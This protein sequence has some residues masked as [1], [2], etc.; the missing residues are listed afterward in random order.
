M[1][2]VA[3]WEPDFEK[4]NRSFG[5]RPNKSCHDAI[6][7]LQSNHTIGLTMALEGDISAAYDNVR[8][9]DIIRCLEMKIRDRKFMRFM[10]TRLNYD[11]VDEENNLRVRPT[12][13]RG[14]PQGGIDSPYLFNI[15]FHE[16]DKF[17]MGEMS[18][19]LNRLNSKAG[20]TASGR[21]PVN[22]V[23]R[24]LKDS[25]PSAGGPD[26]SYDKKGEFSEIKI[27]RV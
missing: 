16:L 19:Y 9:P 15:T 17:V 8:R 13:G 6:V 18:D 23:R 22:R 25:R 4:M 5:F 7:A 14:R 26:Q 24:N 1:V 12:I 10:N 27:L 20:L 2:L 21:R 3:I 11:Y